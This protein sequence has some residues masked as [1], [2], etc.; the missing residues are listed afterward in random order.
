VLARRWDE[1][2]TDLTMLRPEALVASLRAQLTP[3]DM[4]RFLIVDQP[5]GPRPRHRESVSDPWVSA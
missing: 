4:T 3:D 5:P 2:N 1:F